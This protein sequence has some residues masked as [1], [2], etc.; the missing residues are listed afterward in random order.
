MRKKHGGL[1]AHSQIMRVLHVVWVCFHDIGGWFFPDCYRGIA[2]PL[3]NE[4]VVKFAA[5]LVLLWGP[6]QQWLAANTTR[7]GDKEK[8]I[9]WMY[10]ADIP[11]RTGLN[12]EM[13]IGCNGPEE[14]GPEMARR[15]SSLSGSVWNV[16]AACFDNNYHCFLRMPE[17]VHCF[18][19]HLKNFDPSVQDWFDRR[20]SKRIYQYDSVP[21][22]ARKIAFVHLAFLRKLIRNSP[23][24][25][26]LE[27]LFK[28]EAKRT[29][30]IFHAYDVDAEVAMFC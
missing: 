13:F 23:D 24:R 28:L 30:R 11:C 29:A 10:A 26:Q 2:T 12:P 21:E 6:D 14:K 1:L 3:A 5:C 27:K 8:D 19:Y 7:R 22:I 17:D 25:P 4:E 20:M 18:G 9:S 15:I 16:G